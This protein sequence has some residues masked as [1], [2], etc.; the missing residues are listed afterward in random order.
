MNRTVTSVFL[1]AIATAGTALAGPGDPLGGIDIALTVLKGRS[2]RENS[3]EFAAELSGRSIPENS[4]ELA[5]VVDTAQDVSDL[6]DAAM[7]A[8]DGG[9]VGVGT[10]LIAHE[11][12]HVVQQGRGTA[13]IAHELAHVVQQRSGGGALLV[14]DRYTGAEVWN[15]AV[16]KALL[17]LLGG[18]GPAA[19][20]LFNTLTN[21]QKS[22][23]DAAMAA[24]QNTR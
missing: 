12:T 18:N 20:E 23:H 9:S 10:A 21:T 6:F 24:I 4:I 22:K 8:A 5:V 3:L 13:L 7:L 15:Q 11:L 17:D 16:D 19:A 14:V 1:A 2:I